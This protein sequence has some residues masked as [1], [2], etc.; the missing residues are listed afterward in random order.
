MIDLFMV[1]GIYYFSTDEIDSEYRSMI[2]E[3]VKDNV[4]N[5]LN[6][7]SKRLLENTRLYLYPQRT[8][9]RSTVIIDEG[10]EVEIPM[11]ASFKLTYYMPDETYN[12]LQLRDVIISKT[13][14]I[15]NTSLQEPEVSISDLTKQLQIMGG[16]DI[17]AVDLENFKEEGITFT[18]YTNKDADT[19]RSVKRIVEAKPDGTIKVVE[20]IQIIF[21]KHET[22]EELK[23]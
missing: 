1:D 5:D 6:E 22:I 13:K 21:L 16:K 2:S 8:M 4:M 20:D 10:K 14:E 23:R 3:V 11:R 12:D 15:I 17:V 18:V 7:I 9:G 19:R